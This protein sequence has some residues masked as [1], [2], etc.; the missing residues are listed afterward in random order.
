MCC[1]FEAHVAVARHLHGMSEQAVTG[2][3]GASVD[4]ELLEEPR[5]AAIETAH[6]G[7]SLFKM[8]GLDAVALVGR[9]DHAGADRFR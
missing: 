9:G 3:V 1:K 6:A 4:R 5:S 2:H 8:F 7:D